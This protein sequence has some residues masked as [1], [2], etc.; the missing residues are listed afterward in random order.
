MLDVAYWLF[1]TPFVT[2]SLTRLMTL[3]AMGLLAL[4]VG[5]PILF[6]SSWIELP[7]ALLVADVAGYWSH[8]LRHCGLLWHFH[9]IHHSPRTLDSLAAARMHPIDDVLDNTFVGG[10]LFAAGF[11]P[12]VIF[13]IGPVLFVH[14]ALIHADRAWDF[15]PLRW[16]FVSPAHHR[17]HHERGATK[18]FAGM[19]SFLDH[20]FGTHAASTGAPHGTDE[21]IPESVRAHLLW[22]FMRIAQSAALDESRLPPPESIV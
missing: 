7:L 15:G 9:A 2:G 6:S 8:R 1:M 17:A 4:V 13:A 11:S 3:G 21:S 22:P 20:V 12:G 5:R 14:L 19:F 18:N 10:V 16:I